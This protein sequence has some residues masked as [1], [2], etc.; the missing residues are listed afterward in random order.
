MDEYSYKKR[1]RKFPVTTFQEGDGEPLEG[2][3]DMLDVLAKPAKL[4]DRSKHR[5]SLQVEGTSV[6]THTILWLAIGIG[7]LAISPL[8]YRLLTTTHN[9][10]PESM[11][12][13]LPQDTDNWYTLY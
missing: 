13:S 3:E 9:N 2:I 8:I 10:K 12:A 1:S 4:I 7:I 5:M 11:P 6:L